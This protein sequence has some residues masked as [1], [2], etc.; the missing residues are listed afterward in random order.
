MKSYPELNWVLVASITLD[1][2]GQAAEHA[3]VLDYYDIDRDMLIFKNTYD[4]PQSG[5]TKKYEIMRTDT[6]APEELYFV[7]F[8]IRDMATLPSQQQREAN[9]R[10]ELEAK[11]RDRSLF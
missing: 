5:L 10:R 11:I 4:D 3:M 6:N 2:S 1:Y 8:E 9:K 7:H